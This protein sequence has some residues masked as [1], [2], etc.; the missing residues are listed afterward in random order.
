[1]VDTSKEPPCVIIMPKSKPDVVYVHRIEAGSWERENLLKPVAEIGQ[2]VQLLRTASFVVI[3]VATASAVS[4]A[5]VLGKKYLGIVDDFKDVV[6]RGKEA[7]KQSWID[8]AKYFGSWFG[9]SENPY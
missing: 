3:G 8:P 5:W 9:L 2:T 4:V 1:M 6:D 7:V